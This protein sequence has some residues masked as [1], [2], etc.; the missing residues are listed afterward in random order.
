MAVQHLDGCPK[1]RKTEKRTRTFMR[2]GGWYEAKSERCID[3]GAR[4]ASKAKKV[5]DD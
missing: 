1:E 5:K 3:C 2:K 4:N